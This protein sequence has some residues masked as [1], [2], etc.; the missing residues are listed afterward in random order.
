MAN[1]NGQNLTDLERQAE[2]RRAELA[3]TVDELQNRVTPRALQDDVRNY[4]RDTGANMLRSVED[5]VRENPLQSAA[6]AAAL[7]YPIWRMI[8]KMPA[9][10]LLI[11]AGIALSRR[12]SGSG[13]SYSSNRYEDEFDDY[14][15]TA[16][17]RGTV[18]DVKD[19]VGGTVETVKQKVGG[20]VEAVKEKIGDAIGTVRDTASGTA[21]SA[22]STLSETYRS[23]RDM[24]SN[25]ASDAAGQL[26]QTYVRSRD[27]LMD[28]VERHPFVAGAVALAAGSLV[29]MSLPVSRPENRLMGET[30]DE[31][32]KRT[33]EAASDAMTTARDAAQHVVESTASAVQADG[34]TPEV[35]RKAARKAINMA[36]DVAEQTVQDA[37]N[38]FE[39]TGRPPGNSN[40]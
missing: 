31:I 5:R 37:G 10:V 8:G 16:D 12:S 18:A 38:Q 32:K 17:G 9:P 3:S 7:A 4:A 30:S 23:G 27:T 1:S 2:A 24:A 29:A 33:G 11:G 19:A 34:L 40:I 25:M 35:A 26:N 21:A 36:R 39:G 28:A 20:A 15:A 14:P 6:I 22:S 13:R